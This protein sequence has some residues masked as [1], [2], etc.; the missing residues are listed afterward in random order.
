MTLESLS[1]TFGPKKSVLTQVRS[2]SMEKGSRL[3]QGAIISLNTRLI[4]SD[5]L[6]L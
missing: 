5:G 1:V 3:N 6:A 2:S 4:T